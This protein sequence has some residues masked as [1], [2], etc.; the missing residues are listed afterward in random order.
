MH[1]PALK[2]KI[3][4]TYADFQNEEG[5]YE[6]TVEEE[7]GNLDMKSIDI[8]KTKLQAAGIKLDSELDT[9]ARTR[10]VVVLYLGLFQVCMISRK[11]FLLKD[12]LADIKTIFNK[13]ED[14]SQIGIL[15]QK[16]KTSIQKLKYSL[17][18]PKVE[19]QEDDFD[20]RFKETKQKTKEEL[21][22]ELR[23]FKID[24]FLH[25]WFH[26][27]TSHWLQNQLRQAYQGGLLK[28]LVDI[29]PSL[30]EHLPINIAIEHVLNPRISSTDLM[31]R[32][33][34]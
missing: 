26:Y 30:I 16:L 3:S 6:F 19:V 24:S 2:N 7:K 5:N 1:K 8:H 32:F 12:L 29:K 22:E 9:G 4:L 27:L 28:S 15:M 11:F 10:I 20:A 14:P 23:H 25:L 17:V 21:E 31:K 18:P 33:I 34:N 13:Q